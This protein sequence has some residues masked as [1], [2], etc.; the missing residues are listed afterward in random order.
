MQQ[1]QRPRDRIAAMQQMAGSSEFQPPLQDGRAAR[2]Q[3]MGEGGDPGPRADRQ[4]PASDVDKR[5]RAA[6]AER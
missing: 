3:Q 5:A 6:S 4:H 2:P 1:Q